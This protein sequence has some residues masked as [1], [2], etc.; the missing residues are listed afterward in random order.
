MW[1]HAA[2]SVSLV[3]P[4]RIFFTC[5]DA[6]LNHGYEVGYMGGGDIFSGISTTTELAIVSCVH[7]LHYYYRNQ[8]EEKLV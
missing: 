8:E 7:V 5:T 6:V 2:L 4:S 3:D 1:C